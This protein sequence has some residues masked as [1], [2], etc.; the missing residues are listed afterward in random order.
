MFLHRALKKIILKNF[1][2]N[3]RYKKKYRENFR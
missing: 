2:E 3:S 1:N